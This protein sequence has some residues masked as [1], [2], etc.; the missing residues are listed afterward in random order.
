ML[1][2][3]EAGGAV[4]TGPGQHHAAAEAE[5]EGEV[6]SDKQQLEGASDNDTPQQASAE[7]RRG[8]VRRQS[9]LVML[10]GSTS[11]DQLMLPD[12]LVND[13]RDALP[14]QPSVEADASHPG[15]RSHSGE[16]QM[17][18]GSTAYARAMAETAQKLAVAALAAF[19][20]NQD[21]Q[22]DGCTSS[23]ALLQRSDGGRWGGK[24]FS[25]PA[26]QSGGAEDTGGA[27]DNWEGPDGGNDS[28]GE[29]VGRSRWEIRYWHTVQLW[30]QCQFA[31]A[32]S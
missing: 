4:G 18:L 16:Q 27:Y 31:T 30:P 24:T 26:G 11:R 9:S 5:G 23:P 12:S 8:R 14:N 1:Q 21:A 13:L 28:P 10:L 25:R 32:A 29:G 17:V 7:R 15:Q 6:N 20:D 22:Q 3:F 2:E 19:D